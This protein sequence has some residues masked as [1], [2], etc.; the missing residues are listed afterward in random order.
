MKKSV[1]VSIESYSDGQEISQKAQG[2]LYRKG[3]HYYLRYEETE[4][5]MRGTVTTVKLEQARIR[6]VRSGAIRSEQEFIVGKSC[7]GIYE[8]PQGRMGLETVTHAMYYDWS[9][10]LGTVEW[11]YDLFVMGDPAGR[12]RLRFHIA[13][14]QLS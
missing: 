12:Y 6:I 14:R 2:D 4:A 11:S 1:Q 13:E 5:E 9:D 7:Q 8:T 10:G 3:D